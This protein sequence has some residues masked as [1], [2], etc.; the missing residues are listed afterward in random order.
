M[1]FLL[2]QPSTMYYAWQMEILLCN[3]IDI[4]VNLNDVEIVCGGKRTMEWDKLAY[5]YAARFFFY[6]NNSKSNYPSIVRPHILHKHFAQFPSLQEEAIFYIDC[7][8]VFL[9]PLTWI[10]KYLKDNT[11]YLS[12]TK[13]YIGYSY[14][15]SKE[16]GFDMDKELMD[17]CSKINLPFD[18]LKQFDNDSGGAQYILKGIDASFWLEVE[19]DC[20]TIYNFFNYNINQSLNRRF[21][22][23]ENE[24]IQSFCSDMWAVLWNCWK[25]NKQTKIIKDLD[26]AWP[27]FGIQDKERFYIL[28]NAGVVDDSQPIFYKGNY[29]ERLPFEEDFSY[30][31]QSKLSS[32]YVDQIKKLKHTS[33]LIK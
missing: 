26:F 29:L 16:K 19:Q 31:D 23:S 8:V 32:F 6:E 27:A 22:N 20:H 18:L 7:D 24:G 10:E 11:I 17:L 30:I 21:F 13:W 2:A 1:K 9:Q 3:M 12:D 4:G 5:R 25:R 28:H 14:F 33:C 15:K